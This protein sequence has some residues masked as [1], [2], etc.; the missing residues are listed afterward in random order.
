MRTSL[1]SHVSPLFCEHLMHERHSNRTFPDGGRYSFQIPA[2]NISDRE[3]TW[4]TGFEEVWRA[5]KR[6]LGVRQI[7]RREIQAG[8]DKPSL[9]ARYTTIEPCRIRHRA[10]H[11]KEVRNV[12]RLSLFGLII[13]PGFALKMIVS[14]QRNHFGIAMKFYVRSFFDAPD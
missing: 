1:F 13:S 10:G 2:T 14:F 8:L 4:Q 11:R 12:V 7:F 9:I 5:R 3:H 6:P